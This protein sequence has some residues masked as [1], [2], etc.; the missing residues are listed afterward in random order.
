MI[1]T[2]LNDKDIKGMIKAAA[3]LRDAIII[4]L[5]SS[6]GC[7]VSELISIRKDDIDFTNH[8]I[9]IKHLK[10]N[11]RKKCPSCGIT[12]GRKHTFCPKCGNKL[13]I[14]DPETEV[15]RRLVPVDAA[16]LEL[17]A[18]YL[19]KRKSTS[20]KI[21]PLTRQAVYNVIRAAAEDSGLG[22]AVMFLPDSKGAS[23]IG[24]GKHYVHCHSFRDALAVKWL[25]A[26]PSDIEFQKALQEY[27]GHKSF[28]TTTQYYKLVPARISSIYEEVMSGRN[29][30]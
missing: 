1:K 14:T 20:D 4:K 3:C 27:L 6:I 26:K 24:E 28:N 25:T 23:G 15:R 22:G 12:V 29:T 18:D 16:T 2:Y 5:F 8:L 11:I 7:R 30:S 19:N 21:I 17:I 13:E 9:A 10:Q